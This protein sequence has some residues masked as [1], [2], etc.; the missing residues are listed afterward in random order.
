M[1]HGT[2]AVTGAGGTGALSIPADAGPATAARA[3]AEYLAGLREVLR[4]HLG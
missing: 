2:G 1:L 3:R 4:E